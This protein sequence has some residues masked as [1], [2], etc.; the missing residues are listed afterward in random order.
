MSTELGAGAW[1]LL[2]RPARD[3]ARRPHVHRLD[4]DH[5]QR[6]GRPHPARRRFTKKVVYKGL[7]VDDHNNPSLVFRPGRSHRG[8]L[9]P[10]LR[11]RAAAA[12]PP[13]EPD[14]LPDRPAPA[15]DRGLRAGAARQDQRPRRARLHLPQ[16]DPAAR[17][18]VALLARRRL[19]P[20]VLLHAQR[21]GLGARARAARL[22]HAGAAVLEVRRRRQDQHPRHLHR[23][24]RQPLP[25]LPLLPALREQRLLRAQRAQDRELAERPVPHRQ[26]RADLH[27]H[28]RHRERLAARHRA[29][30]TAAA[31]GS[32][33]RGAS[34][35]TTRSSTRTTTGRS[36]SRARSSAPVRASRPSPRAARRS[37]TRTRGSSTSR[38][39]PAPS[40]RSR[41]GSRPTTAAPGAHAS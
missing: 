14:A 18:A 37:T 36:G 32:S 41:H 35:T 23:G 8:V 29:R 34:T 7:G 15:L 30:P 39:A 21:Q 5:R 20:D 12:E 26:A 13:P 33:T 9:Q 24:T 4:L 6:L 11:P 16:P 2:R 1:S 38:A 31:R 10:A 19:E 22:P 25:Q 27:V 28:A 40:T 17:Q 3:L